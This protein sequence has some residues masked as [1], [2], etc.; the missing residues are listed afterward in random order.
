MTVRDVSTVS[1]FLEQFLNYEKKPGIITSANFQEF[2]AH[3]LSHYREIINTLPVVHIAGT[4]G[5]TSITWL[6][7]KVL[8]QHGFKAGTFT[9]PHLRNYEERICINGTPIPSHI[10][11]S[12]LQKAASHR[13]RFPEGNMRTVF[14]LLFIAS[15]QYFSEKKVDS[16]VYETGL[17]GRLDATNV[18]PR[19]RLTLLTPVYKDH[20][21]FLGNTLEKIAQ[22]KAGIMK[23]NVP[24]L[25]FPQPAPVRKVFEKKSSEIGCPMEILSDTELDPKPLLKEI[26]TPM[27]VNTAQ[28]QNALFIKHACRYLG[29][30]TSA[31][32]IHLL[33]EESLPGRWEHYTVNSQTVIFDGTHCL[34]SAK[35]LRHNLDHYFPGVPV[36][37][38]LSFM[39]DKKYREITQILYKPD[40]TITYY[41]SQ[42]R[43]SLNPEA[44]NSWFT[45]H[46]NRSVLILK[47]P[48]TIQAFSTPVICVTGSFYHLSRIKSCL[49]P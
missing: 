42:L 4:K 15:L 9:S 10:L 5:K 19:P 34:L 30:Q 20:T 8:K 2:S 37:F 25:S 22:E 49:I 28:I 3:V 45:S 33:I 17:G 16:A 18:F 43:R 14:E 11:L 36:T 48:L 6:L 21:R 40:D 46:Y 1:T 41:E 24:V 32:D 44:Y 27:Q 7:G 39:Q 13:E 31:R 12:Y 26:N 47:E 35:N 23:T 29:L 38:V